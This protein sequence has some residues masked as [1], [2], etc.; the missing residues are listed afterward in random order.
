MMSVNKHSMIKIK[1]YLRYFKIR[2]SSPRV[3]A[4][5]LSIQRCKRNL[6]KERILRMVPYDYNT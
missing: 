3:K 2:I 4:K 5:M 6:S 1:N